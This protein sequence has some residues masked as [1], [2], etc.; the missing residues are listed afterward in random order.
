MNIYIEGLKGI[1]KVNA[2]NLLYEK[3]ADKGSSV[4]EQIS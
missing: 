1:R 4:T 3:A 2:L